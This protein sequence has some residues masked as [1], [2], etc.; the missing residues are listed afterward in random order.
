MGAMNRLKLAGVLVSL[1]AAASCR[2]EQANS[3]VG[4]ILRVDPRFDALVAANARIEKLADGFVFTEG[5]VWIQSESRLLF[6]DVR[7]N[8]LYQWTEA[9]GASP[10]IDP[11]FEGDLTGRGSVSS[12]GLTLDEEGRL[13][14]CE[15][16]NRLI[17]RLEADGTRTTLVD[18]YQGRRLNS[19]NDAVYS[20][21]GSL[22]FTDPPYGL[23]GLEESPLREL[24]FNGIYRLPPNGE[25]ELLYADQTRPN[26]IALS[27]DETTLYVANS[28]ANQKAW[29]AYD[30]GDEGLT[31]PRVFYD[32]NDQ[33]AEG[34][35]D[36]MTVDL[37]G[38]IFATG[39][40][41]VWVF[42][43]NGTH[44]GNIQPDEVPANVGW[45]DDGRTLYM[46]AR[47][48]LYR[49]RLTTEGRI[50]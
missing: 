32:V 9:E 25:L 50:L 21:D 8:V 24:D 16:G 26:G 43:P 1:I 4:S 46:T 28:D 22:Y 23:E 33:T 3:G 41:G 18:N 44:L 31:N 15:H 38:N 37:A 5:P 12:N 29:Y 6:S 35:A 17:S 30:V 49:I 11:V 13:I 20:A 19:P 48:G 14:I 42:A 47:T 45:G 27:P 2:P 10:L 39:P 34:S 36:G 7:A 40:G